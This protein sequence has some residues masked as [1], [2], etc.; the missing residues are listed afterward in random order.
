MFSPRTSG[1]GPSAAATTN[2][3][4]NPD[5]DP[6]KQPVLELKDIQH[7][8]LVPFNVKA[9]YCREWGP[10]EAFRELVQNW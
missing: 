3:A 9:T 6:D 4:V 7:H 2:F 10:A 8:K 5:H 1:V